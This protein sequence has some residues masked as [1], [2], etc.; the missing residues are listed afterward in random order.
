MNE[1]NYERLGND[2]VQSK[3]LITA[4]I[5]KMTT[6]EKRRYGKLE[7]DYSDRKKKESKK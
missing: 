5:L 4:Y 7:D 6:N 1:F 2:N 3:D